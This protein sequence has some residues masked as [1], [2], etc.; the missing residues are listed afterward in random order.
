MQN[1][2]PTA[3]AFVIPYFPCHAQPCSVSPSHS[4]PSGYF[5][6]NSL[7]SFVLSSFITSAILMP[8]RQINVCKAY[9]EYI[10]KEDRI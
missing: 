9:R 5:L 6:S 4:V 7:Y 2:V 10:T 1:S 8:A 3:F